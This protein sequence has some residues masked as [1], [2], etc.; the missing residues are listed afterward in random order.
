MLLAAIAAAFV[1]FEYG[2]PSPTLIEFRFAAPYNRLRFGLL[3][4]L[5]VLLVYAFR[6]PVETT[7]GTLAVS[8]FAKASFDFW[9]FNY[10]PLQ[11]FLSLAETAGPESRILLGN[12]SGLALSVTAIGVV[13]AGIT[14][15]VYGWPMR[16]EHFN[17]WINMPT[18]DAGSHDAPTTLRRNAVMNVIIALSLPYLAPLAALSFLG[19]LEPISSSNSQFL[20]WLIAI[21]CFVPATSLLR[22]IALFK[23]ASL[24]TK[25]KAAQA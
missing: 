6:E 22:A 20:L 23:V 4:A 24:I 19:P 2:F 21:W 13:L 16:R 12:A 18:F 5:V 1:I 14:V 10:S 25:E 11:S 15:W 8:D 7:A 17:L 9:N 3:A